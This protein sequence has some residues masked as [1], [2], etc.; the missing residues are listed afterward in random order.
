MSTTLSSVTV[1]TVAELS[2]SF[3]L[4]LRSE[5]KSPATVT[6]YLGA[7]NQFVAFLES[8]GMPQSITSIT[9]E[10]VQAFI[11]DQLDRYKTATAHNRYR[12]L[13]VFFKWAVE[14]GEIPA[15][16]MARMKP[17]RMEIEP[18]RVLNADELKQLLTSVRGRTFTAHRDTAIVALFADTGLRLSELANMR[19]ADVDLDEGHVVVKGKGRKVRVVP[20]GGRAARLLDRYLRARARQSTAHRAEVWLGHAGPMTPN[21]I[22]QLV[23]RIGKRAGVADLHP[24]A[25]RHTFAHMWL[26]AGGTETDLM[27]IMGWSS[28]SMLE[29]YASTTAGE[30]AR[31]AHRRLSP[32]DNA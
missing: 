3:R 20:F 6:A 21:G 8:T 2:A 27:R 22:G 30:R 9:R 25:F 28:R 17:P 4:V 29:R 19:L 31:L 10:H 7:L 32:L 11:T 12:G 15:S 13:D 14:D 1:P 18:P 16:P 26:A 24:H 5:N 23:R